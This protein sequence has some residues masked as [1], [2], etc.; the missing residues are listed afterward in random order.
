MT[1]LPPLFRHARFFLLVAL[2]SLLAGC[3]FD[4]NTDAAEAEI[5]RF[6]QALDAGRHAEL[7]DA[8]GAELKSVAKRE[9]FLAL[10]GA[11]HRKLGNVK[12][13]KRTAWNVNATL[14]GSLITLAYETEFA[15]GK[16]TETFVYRMD[17]KRA[18]L[19]GYNIASLALIIK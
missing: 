18:V 8:A 11:V 6:H 1:S 2:A 9:D 16:A 5:P 3:S 10:L 19:M 15:E 12:S 17:D 4:T 7:Y 14:S 13:T